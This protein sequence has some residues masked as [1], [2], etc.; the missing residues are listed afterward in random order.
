MCYDARRPDTYTTKG[1]EQQNELHGR[2][3]RVGEVKARADPH[4]LRHFY[5]SLHNITATLTVRSQL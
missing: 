3:T 1:F 5:V 2:E 4:T